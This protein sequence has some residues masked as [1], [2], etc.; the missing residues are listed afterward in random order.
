MNI[1]LKESNRRREV[2]DAHADE[3]AIDYFVLVSSTQFAIP[4]GNL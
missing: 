3:P 4:K 2:F 1:S